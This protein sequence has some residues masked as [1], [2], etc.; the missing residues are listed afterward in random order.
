MSEADSRYAATAAEGGDLAT[1]EAAT[2][3]D[4]G[5]GLG[6]PQHLRQVRGFGDAS[7]GGL[8][9]RQAGVTWKRRR[10]NAGRSGSGLSRSKGRRHEVQVGPA[11][12]SRIIAEVVLCQ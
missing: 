3:A 6:G 12:P 8:K 11:K 4:D 2:C 10:L 5:G 1:V 9:Q 7:L